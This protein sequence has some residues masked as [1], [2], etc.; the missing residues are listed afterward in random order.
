M[1]HRVYI[2]LDIV[3]GTAEQVARTLQ[4][5]PGVIIVDVLESLPVVMLENPPNVIMMIQ[6]HERRKLAELTIQALASVET[7]IEH[8][9]LLPAG[10]GLSTNQKK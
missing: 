10:D 1:V 9:C 7:M 5:K 6:A 2:L 8:V 4:E 3:D